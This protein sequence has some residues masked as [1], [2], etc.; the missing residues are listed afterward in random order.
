MGGTIGA[1]YKFKKGIGMNIGMKYYY[2]FM[3]IYKSPPEKTNN[4]YFFFYADIPIGAQ[5]AKEAQ[6]K[7]NEN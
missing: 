3:N 7:E 2:G 4:S 1:G 5:K 6:A